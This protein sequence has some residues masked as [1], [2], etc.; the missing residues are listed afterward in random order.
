MKRIVLLTLALLYSMIIMG[1]GSVNIISEEF[2][3]SGFPEGWTKAG[4]GTNSW[5]ISGSA[6]AGGKPNELMLQYTMPFNGIARFVSPAVDMT[7]ISS[8]MLSLNHY[9][10]LF[11]TTGAK[12]GVATSSDG[13]NIWHSVWS[14]EY[15]ETNKQHSIY[16]NISGPDM[17]KNN[18]LFCIY[19]EGSSSAITNW[20]FDD[21]KV[22]TVEDIGIEI[23]SI[24]VNDRICY[25]ENPIRFSVRSTGESKIKSFEARCV[26]NGTEELSESFYTEMNYNDEKQFTYETY[27]DFAI[28]TDYEI[29]IEIFR[30][31]DDDITNP[32][33]SVT[34]TVST[35]I[36]ETQRTP[37]I[38][39]FSSATCGP[40]VAANN[41]MST[42][43]SNNPGKYT[44]TKYP[45]NWPSQGD[46]YFTTETEVKRY[47]Y[48]ISGAPEL[49]LDGNF[50]GMTYIDDETFNKRYDETSLANVRGAFTV[51]G[52]TITVTA[53]FMTYFDAENLKAYISVNE[54]TT[55]GNAVPVDNN[56][57][58]ETEFHHIMMKMLPDA[59]GSTLNIKA[60]EH[61]HLEL[62]YDMSQTF[63]EDINDLEV[64]I[65]LQNDSTKE[66][67]N[68]HFAY[69][70]TDHCYPVR[71]L[72]TLINGNE[73]TL[74]WDKPEKGN[75]E[76][77]DIYIDGELV[78][79]KTTSLEYTSEL[80]DKKAVEVVAVYKDNMTSVG[81]AKVITAEDNVN[82]IAEN[83]FLYVYPNPAKDEIHISSEERL[84]E[85][86]I[87]NINGQQTTVNSQ[88][89]SS[90]GMTINISNLNSG[91]Y[92]IKINTEKGNIVK[93]FI[94]Y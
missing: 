54:K 26:I 4:V 64:A 13:G 86:R 57:N 6:M 73:L 23:T 82:D 25:G 31:N 71:Q 74:R 20:C 36:G 61:K 90:T 19:F 67:Y 28:D 85:V 84:E 2:N 33:N 1:Q 17:G 79:E 56:G 88:Q 44:Y 81:I 52:N 69:E 87:Y 42:L 15:K 65:W 43:T 70:Y 75:P 34:K 35:S 5:F 24:D 58:G 8:A 21:F 76:G 78:A 38:E 94:K 68:S 7:G 9:V 66:I 50:Y 72:T 41:G 62:S 29:M 32:D 37:M 47:Y 49:Y 30:I 51:E 77:Y 22:F 55:T 59:N 63:M 46:P 60:G 45:M 53:D 10:A 83:N 48:N 16:T 11:G 91:V 12:V 93:Q 3:D 40:C 39:H 89:T 18:V 92:F 14:D 80:N 27:Y